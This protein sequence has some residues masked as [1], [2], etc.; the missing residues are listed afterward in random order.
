M[1]LTGKDILAKVRRTKQN[2][3]KRRLE[4]RINRVE[5]RIGKESRPS[6]HW[7]SN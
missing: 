5:S 3:R 1:K 6:W 4:R 2:S 7:P